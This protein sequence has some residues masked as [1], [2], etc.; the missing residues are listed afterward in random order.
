MVLNFFEI[1]AQISGL[2]IRQTIF[3]NF[4]QAQGNSQ[5]IFPQRFAKEFI[6]QK[7]GF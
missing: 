1:T 5:F 2:I 7:K 4:L 3:G 6:A